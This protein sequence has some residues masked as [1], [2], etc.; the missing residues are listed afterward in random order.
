MPKR[1][2]RLTKAEIEDVQRVMDSAPQGRK[3]T[4]RQIARHF[5]VTRS[6]V[7]KSLGGW[8]GIQR[9][10]LQRP[11]PSD[12]PHIPLIGSSSPVKIEPHTV[13]VLEEL[14]HG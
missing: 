13:K 3:P 8:K 1:K 2:R 6:M 9:G 12:I 7:I 10:A 5:G 14:Q 11:P 4:I